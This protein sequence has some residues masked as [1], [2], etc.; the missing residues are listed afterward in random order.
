M[1]GKSAPT[2]AQNLRGVGLMALGFFLFAACDVQAKFLTDELHAVQIVWF[3]Q[4]GLLLGV[5]ALLALKGRAMLASRLPWVQIARGATAVVS[6]ICFV[7]GITHVPLADAVAVTFVA[8]FIVT[9]MGAL[10]LGEPVGL[11]RWLAVAVGFFGMLIVIRPGMGV[12]HPAILF[13]LAA[14]TMFALRQVL[15]RSLS[16]V[17]PVTT[18]MAYTSLTGTALLSLG[19]PFVWQTPESAQ[20][21]LILAG[22]ALTAGLGEVLVIRALDIAWAVVLAPVHYT[23][24]LW[25]TFYGFV[26]FSELPDGWT[27]LGC[28]VIVASGFYT[29]HRE[30]LAARRAA[31]ASS[32]S[33]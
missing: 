10:F 13:V 28:A 20:T 26:V 11:R 32:A 24:I 6:A 29:L 12:F 14:A 3:R 4:L 23:M 5:L 33:E 18:T 25:G 2:A 21:W 7:V 31:Q 9:A 17:D 1:P 27:L 22:L 19:L 8:P 30:R 15:S 16:G